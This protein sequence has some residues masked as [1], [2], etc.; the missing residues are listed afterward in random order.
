MSGIIPRIETEISPGTIIPKPGT[1]REYCVKGWGRR[2]GERA[3]IYLIP[4][5]NTPGSPYQKGITV[6]EWEKAFERLRSTGEFRC[7]WFN[8]A[9]GGCRTEGGSNYLTFGGIFALLGLV[10]RQERGVCRRL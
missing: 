2:R 5:L 6:S 8:A 7:S 10:A 1:E 4:N 3:L 9:M